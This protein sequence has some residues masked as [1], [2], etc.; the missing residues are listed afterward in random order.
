VIDQETRPN[1][2]ELAAAFKAA[3]RRFA[4][5]VTIVTVADGDT[6]SGMTAT[7]VASVSTE[8][9]ALLVCVNRSASIHANLRMGA[10]FCVN[11]LAADH[12]P[13]SA[14]FG[15]KLPPEDRFSLGAWQ[16]HGTGVPYL[17]DA[18][19]N[20]FCVVDAMIE[21]GTHTIF[22][23]RAEAVRLHGEVR[24]LIYGDGRFIG[25]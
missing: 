16:T 23:G 18:Q 20:I 10:N 5:T 2:V 21:Y 6:K 4:A 25:A 8:P 7:A 24:P 17:D 12:I 11:L 22:I 1:P 3:M 15:G 14:A 13:L 19:A 9:P